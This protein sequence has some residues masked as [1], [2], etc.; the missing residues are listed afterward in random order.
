MI[1]TDK[2]E[3]EYFKDRNPGLEPKH[4]LEV[5]QLI[6]YF[7]LM[8]DDKVYVHGCG[9]GQR[10]HWFLEFGMNAWGMEVSRYA[11]DNAYGKAHGRITTDLSGLKGW[12][13]L[14]V[15]V[16]VLEHI[17]PDYIDNIVYRLSELSLKAVYGITFID[18]KNFPKDPTHINGKTKQEWKD[19]L[20][21]FYK[22]VYD[23]PRGWYE[24][25][26]YLICYKK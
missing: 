20:S 8:P 16:D 26:M 7:S 10:L 24:G 9:Y 4:E 21:R 19:F 25:H 13:D 6:R 5:R 12:Y 22:R 18:N 14:V 1:N 15:S 17:H 3:E 11:I 2:F 23:A